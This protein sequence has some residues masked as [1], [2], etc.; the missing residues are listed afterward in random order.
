[1]EDI[2][3]EK[4]YAELQKILQDLKAENTPLDQL[5]HKV[6]RA[7]ELLK[8]CQESLRA[9]SKAVHSLLEADED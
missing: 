1:M 3:Y 5:H 6:V 7:K 2:T 9:T 4:A 8:Y